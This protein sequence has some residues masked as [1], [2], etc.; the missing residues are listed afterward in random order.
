MT[1]GRRIARLRPGHEE[2]LARLFE[3]IARDPAA[4]RFHPHAFTPE[5]A[6]AICGH[7]GRDLYFGMVEGGE[8]VAYGMLRGWDAGYETPSLGIYVAEPARG[9]GAARE[10]MSCLHEAARAQGAKRV[11]LKVYPDNLPARRL[12]ESLGYR[13]EPGLEGGQLVGFKALEG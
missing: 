5:A 12:Y 8:F 3:A 6:R 7:A 1:A 13:M 9:S 4:A 2:A 10:M 11:R